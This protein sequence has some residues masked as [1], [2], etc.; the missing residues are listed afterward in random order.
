MTVWFMTLAILGIHHIVQRPEILWALSP[1]HG[2]AFFF[3]HGLH[4]MLILGS[5]VL[6]VTGGEALYADMGHFGVRPIRLAW[7]FFVLPALALCYLGQ[8]A[9]VLR[10]PRAI[11]NPFYSLVPTGWPTYLLI[12]LS[13]AATVIASQAL[14]S[15]AFS[16]TRQA[17]MLGYL[18]R[19]TIKH[20][21]Y[22]TEGQIYIPEVN[23]MLAVA[24]SRWC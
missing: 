8:G 6:A 17:M 22:H 4:G 2:V 7:S 18:P 21:A 1:H 9:L 3:R 23:T 15:G 13:S 12:M 14:I 20:T 10:D 5:V 19:M 16:L 24:A 11:E